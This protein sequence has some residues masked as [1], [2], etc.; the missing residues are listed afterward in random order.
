LSAA[1]VA[2]SQST[3]HGSSLPASGHD[4]VVWIGRNVEARDL[5]LFTVADAYAQARG[6][7]GL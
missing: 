1:L 7:L 2:I 6:Q 4:R 5:V 3:G